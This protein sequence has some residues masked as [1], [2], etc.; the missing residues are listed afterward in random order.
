[1]FY[2]NF[3]TVRI[4]QVLAAMLSAYS[5]GIT[6]FGQAAFSDPASDI[7]RVIQLCFKSVQDSAQ[8]IVNVCCFLTRMCGLSHFFQHQ[9]SNPAGDDDACDEDEEL[10][11]LVEETDEIFDAFRLLMDA[12]LSTYKEP[13]V[14]FAQALVL[15]AI[16]EFL[17]KP[18]FGP[19][20]KATSMSLMNS[21]VKHGGASGSALVPFILPLWLA[22]SQEEDA[23]VRTTAFY[24]I[25]LCAISNPGFIN[26]GLAAIWQSLQ[27]V[28]GKKAEMVSDPEEHIVWDNAVAATFRL[29]QSG[30]LTDASIYNGLLGLFPIES[31]ADEAAAVVEIVVAMS[32]RI[33]P[34]AGLRALAEQQVKLL[35]QKHDGFE[36]VR[37]IA[38]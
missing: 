23:D 27:A 18:L 16:G 28:I 6:T 4:V 34:P 31:D 22:A 14:A 25:G 15:P 7:P 21:I 29:F 11:P 20:I 37:A 38:Q 17:S 10:W 36:Q 2:C 32:D 12:L 35:Q 19:E 5:S 9:T 30:L 13:C 24:G 33:R 8:N 3:F 1:M 26:Q